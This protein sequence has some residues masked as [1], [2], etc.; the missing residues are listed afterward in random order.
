MLPESELRRISRILLRVEGFGMPTYFFHLTT[1]CEK[2]LDPDGTQLPNEAA[3]R[4]HARAVARDLMQY[5]NEQTRSWRIVVCE[6]GGKHCF[7]LLFVTVDDTLD[8][9]Q[10]DLRKSCEDL[11][12]S[13][14]SLFDTVEE[15]RRTLLQEIGR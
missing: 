11:H 14:V 4:E 9:Y 10:P 12:V 8:L 2:I 3:A 13:C 15:V 7:D 1:V 6:D 5:R